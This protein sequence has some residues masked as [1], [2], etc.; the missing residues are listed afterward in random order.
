MLQGERI[1]NNDVTSARH[2][3]LSGKVQGVGFRPFIYRLATEH[4]L[5]GWVRN[6]V[7]LVEIHVQGREQ[8]LQQFV[9]E[10]FSRAPQLASPV[11]QSD[12]PVAAE[13]FETFTILE[14]LDQGEANISVPADLFTCD[15]CLAEFT[16]P[17]DR[18]YR[19]PFINCTQCGPRYTLIRSL[20]YDRSNT[21]MSG[22]ELCAQCQQEYEDPADRRFHAEPVACPV[23]G[24][25]LE[26]RTQDGE[27][28]EGN[29]QALSVAIQ[30]LR[31]GWIIA[32]K[33]IGGY[34]LICDACNDDAV[35]KLRTSKPRPDKP[36]AVLFPAAAQDPFKALAAAVELST[37]D[38]EFLASPARPILL[39]QK[40]ADSALSDA[41]APALNEIGV[42][43]PYSPLHH[44]LLN[45]FGGPLVA[46][47]ANI[48]GEPVLIANSDVDKRLAH[49]ADACLHHDRPIERPAD[50]PVFRIIAGKPRPM[51]L[52][53]GFAPRE[54]ALPFKLDRPVLAV[55][56]HMKNTI[57]LAWGQRAVISP[58]IGEMDSARSLV[59]FEQTVA[60]LQRLYDVTI[61]QIVCDYHPGYMTTRWAA[62]QG[63][64]VHKVFHHYAHASSAYYECALQ[65]A[66]LVFTWDG[67]GF[68]ADQTLW[69]GEAM[70]GTPGNWRR[71]ASM[72]PFHLPGGEKAGR[73]HWR[74]AAALCW[75]TGREYSAM[76]ED[77]SLLAEAWRRRINSPQSSA[78][79][80]LFDAAAALTGVCT[81]ASFEGQGPMALEAL[82]DKL[83]HHVE[84]LSEKRDNV[85]IT[86]WEPLVPV[87]LDSTLSRRERAA[88]FH[89]SLA[90][91]ILQ[92][93]RAIRNEYDVS[94]VSFAGGVFQ[95]R[96][97]TEH[98]L[99]L[100]TSDGFSV[101]LPELIPVND[102][103]I[104][105]GQVIEYGYSKYIN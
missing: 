67:T 65:Q 62:R 77:D 105:F 61:E 7:G 95:N 14:S 1:H 44:L 8:R 103:G 25:R 54:L 15:E 28:V 29:E 59:V 32:V 78:V 49:V 23:C 100:L 79:G 50:D 5:T 86:N 46:T 36:L 19:Y 24:P 57:A 97:L 80:R 89:A 6:R 96:V 30:A 84:L 82:C 56:A 11:L 63:L 55:G 13:T 83:D 69:G 48:S 21:T 34:H 53:R 41:I 75:E 87:M 85:L 45:D 76:P 93:A 37:I 16:L 10:I 90:Y 17:S 88:V 81:M 73:E 39:V 66:V 12:S 38:K 91:A 18:R 4:C 26:Y 58:H 22:F 40:R 99:A 35:I 42:M 2:I 98:A 72:R 102:A 68:G 3:V 33:G 47:S 101:H 60:D 52:G 92:Q 31:K 43:L 9:T 64:P 71:V 94:T 74:C 20:P 70:L 27:V 104:S 51:R